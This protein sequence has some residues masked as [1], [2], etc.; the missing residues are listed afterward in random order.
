[1]RQS[2]NIGRPVSSFVFL[3]QIYVAK[4][5]KKWY[6]HCKTTK[7]WCWWMFHGPH[8]WF[9]ELISNIWDVMAYLTRPTY[10][11]RW[12]KAPWRDKKICIFSYKSGNYLVDT[13]FENKQIIKLTWLP[14]IWLFGKHSFPEN[15]RC[16][17][18]FSY[19]SFKIKKRTS[20]WLENQDPFNRSLW[21]AVRRW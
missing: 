7:T 15:L 14:F 20:F 10:K 6:F 3:S 16:E 5:T 19:T 1:M 21:L 13:S 17:S 11:A 2:E 9:Q 12:L 4:L 8:Q 18:I